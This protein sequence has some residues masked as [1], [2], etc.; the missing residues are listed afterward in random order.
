MWKQM[1]I[2][3][4]TTAFSSNG[5]TLGRHKTVTLASG[6]KLVRDELQDLLAM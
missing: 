5:V 2:S 6:L 1:D 4:W 3:L